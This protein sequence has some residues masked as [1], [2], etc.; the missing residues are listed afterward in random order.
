[1]RDDLSKLEGCEALRVLR[2]PGTED[3]CLALCFSMNRYRD[4][5]LISGGGASGRKMLADLRAFLLGLAECAAK[6]T[7]VVSGL[8]PEVALRRESMERDMRL[9]L[10]VM[11]AAFGCC[12][13]CSSSGFFRLLAL[14]VFGAI[15]FIL[16]PPKKP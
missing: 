11:E 13:S 5:A 8:E 7:D 4:W 9:C 2:S 15:D 6:A 3:R 14:D 10:L 16:L 1:M 12:S